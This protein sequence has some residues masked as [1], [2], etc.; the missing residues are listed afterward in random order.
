MNKNKR[1]ILICAPSFVSPILAS[2]VE[3]GVHE[4]DQPSWVY[5]AASS[6][7]EAVSWAHASLEVV[8]ESHTPDSFIARCHSHRLPYVHQE[9]GHVHEQHFRVFLVFDVDNNPGVALH[10]T[11]AVFD[12]S[13]CL[14]FFYVLLS[15]L[16]D[17]ALCAEGYIDGL[18]WGTEWQNLPPG[19]I[20][21]TGGPKLEWET[22]G[23]ELL[24]VIQQNLVPPGVS[25]LVTS[26]TSPKKLTPQPVSRSAPSG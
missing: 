7:A 12:A 23:M 25:A 3:I 18:A 17:P 8:E 22:K 2:T 13:P 20:I 26:L 4:P 1:L 19:P 24:T 10:G 15:Y 5:T 21:S 16:T 9:N 6:Y 11:H 14:N